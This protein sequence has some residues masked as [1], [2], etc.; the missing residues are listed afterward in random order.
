[1]EAN[2]VIVFYCKDCD[3][4]FYAHIEKYLDKD[5]AKT[6]AKYLTEGHRLEKISG[7]EVR[8]S[9]GSGGCGSCSKDFKNKQMSLLQQVLFAKL[10]D[11]TRGR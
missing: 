1:M 8:K 9:W 5:D 10:I 11:F 6:I 3:N 7:A 4:L 2:D